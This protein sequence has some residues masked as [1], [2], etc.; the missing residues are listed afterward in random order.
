MKTPVKDMKFDFMEQNG[1]KICS[2]NKKKMP[3][4]WFHD[5][6]AKIIKM[7]SGLMWCSLLLNHFI[8]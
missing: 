2:V 3:L 8:F 7:Y 4:K 1:V 5:C 6:G